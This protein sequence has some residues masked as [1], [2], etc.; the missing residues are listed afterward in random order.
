MSSAFY[1]KLDDG[2][3]DGDEQGTANDVDP[4]DTLAQC[5]K[6]FVPHLAS[7]PHSSSVPTSLYKAEAPPSQ[8]Q[9]HSNLIDFGNDEPGPAF[10]AKHAARESY[11]ELSSFSSKAFDPF[12]EL[13]SMPVGDEPSNL[14]SNSTPEGAV[15]APVTAEVW[16]SQGFDPFQPVTCHNDPLGAYLRSQLAPYDAGAIPSANGQHGMDIA[17]LLGDGDLFSAPPPATHQGANGT[18]DSQRGCTAS[19]PEGRPSSCTD[20]VVAGPDGEGELG[21]A[22]G[23]HVG[24]QRELRIYAVPLCSER[25]IFL[26]VTSWREEPDPPPAGVRGMMSSSFGRLQDWGSNMWNGMKEKEHDTFQNKVYRAGTSVMENMSSEERLMNYIPKLATKVLVF[27]PASHDAGEVQDRL[28]KLAKSYAM[29]SAGKAAASGIVL[30]VAVTAEMLAIPGVG[31]IPFSANSVSAAGGQRL[32]RYLN[33]GGARVN[34]APEKKLDKYCERSKLSPDGLLTNDD[35]EDMCDD[36]REDGLQHALVELRVRYLKRITS[37]RGAGEGYAMLP[38]NELDS[39]DRGEGAWRKP[40]TEEGADPSEKEDEK[41]S[42]FRG[43]EAKT[44]GLGSYE[45]DGDDKCNNFKVEE[46]RPKRLGSYEED[47]DKKWGSLK[48]EEAWPVGS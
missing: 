2:G 6:A 22:D 13:A 32:N 41:W 3:S 16:G 1:S 8:N 14:A 24:E 42:S 10:P 4:W 39:S 37:K 7:V 31:R 33:K 5:T 28:S 43:N 15:S 21:E 40:A 44:K 17:N 23:A 47:G 27:F 36:L 25:L 19:A 9:N 48:K 35:I 20:I 45:E 18:A 30:P 12:A 38:V 46:A 26:P 34:Y 11:I 29:K